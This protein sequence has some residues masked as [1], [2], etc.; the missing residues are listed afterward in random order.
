[1]R[2][3]G[4]Q[5]EKVTSEQILA[6]EEMLLPVW[7]PQFRQRSRGRNKPAGS[8]R[9]PSVAEVRLTGGEVGWEPW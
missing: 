9:D 4:Y 2:I 5:G 1:M 6:G 3:G 8:G 7:R